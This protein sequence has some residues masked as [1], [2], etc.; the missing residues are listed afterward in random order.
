M[1]VLTI[2]AGLVGLVGLPHGAADLP[3]GRAL[4]KRRSGP[5]WVVPF[6]GFYLAAA[7]AVLIVWQT[8]PQAAL[9]IFLALSIWHFGQEDA[10][11]HFEQP[12]PA[13]TLL[14]GLLPIAVPSLVWT[15]QTAEIFQWLVQPATLRADYVAQFGSVGCGLCAVL[16]ILRVRRMTLTALAE[17]SAVVLLF[18]AL[19]PLLAFAVY[20]AAIHS[21]RHAFRVHRVLMT[22]GHRD[23]WIFYT[24]TGLATVAVLGTA[25][26]LIARMAGDTTSVVSLG[27]ATTIVMF[28]GLSALTVPHMILIALRQRSNRDQSGSFA[29]SAQ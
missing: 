18:V 15:G 3:L 25:A 27:E 6:F 19:P 1:L 24:L 21:V 12:G 14:F 26:L 28:Q 2:A 22:G 13:D 10:H 20:F 4:F 8:V 11:A 29:L 5:G 9:I 23:A 17:V 16:A 7:A